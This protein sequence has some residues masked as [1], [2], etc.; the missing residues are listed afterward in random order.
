MSSCRATNA[1]PGEWTANI[2]EAAPLVTG[3]VKWDGCTQWWQYGG[4]HVDDAGDFAAFC[5]ALKTARH[6]AM[7]ELMTGRDEQAD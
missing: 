5:E 4:G 6:V 2:D 7:T 1:N 3:F